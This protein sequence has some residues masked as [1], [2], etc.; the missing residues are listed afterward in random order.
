VGRYTTE[1]DPTRTNLSGAHLAPITARSTPTEMV[2]GFVVGLILFMLG[3]AIYYMLPAPVWQPLHL[4]PAFW[5]L[6]AT[7]FIGG[8]LGWGVYKQRTLME[9]QFNSMYAHLRRKAKVVQQREVLVRAI[10]DNTPDAILVVDHSG[11]V[12]D[13]NAAALQIFDYPHDEFIGKN[14]EEII[15]GHDKLQSSQRIE[16]RTAMG[17]VLGTEWHAKGRHSDGMTFP[18][19]L[20]RKGMRDMPA[21][22]YVA[23]EATTRIEREEGRVREAL[24]IERQELQMTTK[25][26]GHILGSIGRNM[27]TEV[28]T[29]IQQAKALAKDGTVAILE[30]A[31]ELLPIADRLQNLSMADDSQSELQIDRV[32]VSGLVEEVTAAV[33]PVIERNDT[34]LVVRLADNVGFIKTDRQKLAH[35]VRNLMN[36]AS[37]HTQEGTITLEVEREPGRGTDWIAFHI[38]DTA[39]GMSQADIDNLFKAFRNF[40]PASSR[41]YLEQGLGLALSQHCA[42]LLGGHIAVRSEVGEGSTFTLRVPMRANRAGNFGDAISMD[43][44]PGLN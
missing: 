40:N 14:V 37:H 31:H 32:A 41:E 15:P 22:V 25:R 29:L 5:I 8:G 43:S 3:C 19:D 16:R 28:D 1:P 30:T 42:K 18:I 44:D 21:M 20:V 6:L 2:T 4:T 26:R 39:G 33:G 7:P 11:N 35:A 23:K 10:L 38:T 9:D 27:R 34:R 13:C 36:N 12:Q 24:E 17:D